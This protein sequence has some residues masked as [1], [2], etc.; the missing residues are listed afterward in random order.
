MR[1][2]VPVYGSSV[3]NV[4][5]E[6]PRSSIPLRAG[7]W[8]ASSELSGEYPSIVPA[9]LRLVTVFEDAF[10]DIALDESDPIAP[11]LP[12]RDITNEFGFCP[13]VIAVPI[14]LLFARSTG[15]SCRESRLATYSVSF[16]VP[17]RL[18]TIRL[19]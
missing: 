19:L 4:R 3:A 15:T 1:K 5:F 13:R 18:P 9:I 10:S 16:D 6:E 2:L 7:A 8:K 14:E 12:S 17:D 11:K